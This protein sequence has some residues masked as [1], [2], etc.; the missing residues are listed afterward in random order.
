MGTEVALLQLQ[1][2]QVFAEDLVLALAY[3][4]GDFGIA[5]IEAARH[6]PEVPHGLLGLRRDE[7]HH[8]AVDLVLVG[9]VVAAV[10]CVGHADLDQHMAGRGE[11][12]DLPAVH[13][14]IVGQAVA[15]Q[16]HLPERGRGN[17][18]H[19]AA[20]DHLDIGALAARL[21]LAGRLVD[22]GLA[23]GAG[24]HIGLVRQVHEV[25]DHQPVVG[26]DVEHAAAIGPFGVVV[27]GQLR[28][29]RG[30]GQRLVA[31]NSKSEFKQ[32][33]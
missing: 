11:A 18:V 8:H 23:D 7:V 9:R 28:D 26:L 19:E 12:A 14:H 25:V 10:A 6:A 1:H 4:V 24:V 5:R 16:R 17:V 2:L 20:G 3:A 13:G 21:G 32:P 33:W 22:L 29:E 27:P 31:Q 15:A 30:I